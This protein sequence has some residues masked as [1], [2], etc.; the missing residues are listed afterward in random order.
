MNIR[1]RIAGPA[2]DAEVAAI[3]TETFYET[4]HP[5]YTPED[6]ERYF[7]S[8]FTV[9]Q[10]KALLRDPLHTLVILFYVDDHPAGYAQLNFGTDLKEFEGC[11]SGEIERFYFF[12]RYH[13][14]GVAN[15]L[16]ETVLDQFRKRGCDWVFLGV[17]VNN[18]RAIRFYSRYGFKVFG[19]KDF[20]VGSVVETDQL[21]KMKLSPI[22][23]K[24]LSV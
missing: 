6:M 14:T 11:S 21:M 8:A 23:R 17:D 22:S 10:T 16:M 9:E 24:S 2:D 4:W 12:K 13:G 20:V 18:H 19:K 3:G 15:Q 1:W 7:L 5:F